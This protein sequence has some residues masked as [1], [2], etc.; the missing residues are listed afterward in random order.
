MIN[1]SHRESGKPAWECRDDWA[2]GEIRYFNKYRL[3]KIMFWVG[4]VVMLLSAVA[5]VFGLNQGGGWG[6]MTLSLF[7]AVWAL[8]V[9]SIGYRNRAKWQRYGESVFYMAEVPGVIGGSLVGVVRADRNVDS[10]EGF[11]VGLCCRKLRRDSETGPEFLWGMERIVHGERQLHEGGGTAIPVMFAIPIEAVESNAKT[12]DAQTFWTL[13]VRSRS[14]SADYFSE[15]EVP[16]Y[17]T[18]KSE[19]S[20]PPDET[21]I[22]KYEVPVDFDKQF[23][24]SGIVYQS[25]EGG[26]LQFDF[27]RCPNK[28]HA[29]AL[30]GLQ[31]I[32]SFLVVFAL[33]LLWPAAWPFVGGVLSVLLIPTLMDLYLLHSRVECHRDG[34]KVR[35]G[36][37]FLGPPRQIDASDIKNVDA[38]NRGPTVNEFHEQTHFCHLFV[39]LK[40]GTRILLAKRVFPQSVASEIV[41][42]L[43]TCVGLE[44]PTLP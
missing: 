15:F 2:K 23:V 36:K 9:I 17:R 39:E 13:S 8:G 31:A 11:H 12:K 41:R 19:R 29:I 35:S 43:E 5:F 24:T 16:V 37:F 1:A 30:V 34:L 25:L 27:L 20:L 33:F 26:G 10:P 32:P 38:E 42:R 7:L 40:N 28:S 44:H 4:G 22:K 14:K 21:V 6:G 3:D 18:S